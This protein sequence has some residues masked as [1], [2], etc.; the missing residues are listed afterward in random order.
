MLAIPSSCG[1]APR[2]DNIGGSREDL[3]ERTLR[4]TCIAGHA[5]APAVSIPFATVNGLPV[6]L[7]LVGMPGHDFQVLDLAVALWRAGQG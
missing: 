7:S 1:P 3:R 2:A 6:G 4:M 5:G